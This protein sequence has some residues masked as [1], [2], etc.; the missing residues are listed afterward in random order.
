MEVILYSEPIKSITI[1]NEYLFIFI[2]QM[3]EEE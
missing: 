1:N 2:Y 3:K